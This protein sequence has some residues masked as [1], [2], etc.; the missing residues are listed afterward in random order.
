MSNQGIYWI[1]SKF[2]SKFPIKIHQFPFKDRETIEVVNNYDDSD[3]DREDDNDDD[4]GNDDSWDEMD[5]DDQAEPTKCLFCDQVDNSIEKSIEHLQ[6]QHH[7]SF[8]AA[9]KKFHLDQYSY[10][11]V[12]G[13]IHSWAF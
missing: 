9:K 12:T 4:D 11:K 8:S 6:Q 7:I 13:D 3:E 10:I 1:Y 2:S 5:E